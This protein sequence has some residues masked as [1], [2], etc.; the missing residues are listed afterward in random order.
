M[1]SLMEVFPDYN[2]KEWRSFK[3]DDIKFKENN[4]IVEFFNNYDENQQTLFDGT[5]GEHKILKQKPNTSVLDKVDQYRHYSHS[6][7]GFNYTETPDQLSTYTYKSPSSKDFNILSPELE[8][9]LFTKTDVLTHESAIKHINTCFTCKAKV[10]EQLGIELK[11]QFDSQ[12]RQLNK[13][14]DRIDELLEV[15]TFILIGIALIYILDCAVKF[16][17]SRIK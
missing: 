5:N 7:S 12:Y 6:P 14:K 16:G 10:K 15:V 9:E 4:N 17:A 13:P 11:E 2:K 3:M 8:Q 1:A